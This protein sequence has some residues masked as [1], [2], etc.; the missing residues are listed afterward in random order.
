MIK[1]I[2]QNN[3][4]HMKKI[5]FILLLSFIVCLPV[6]ATDYGDVSN[7]QTGDITSK[8]VTIDN[9]LTVSSPQ[10]LIGN[11]IAAV[12]GLVG[13]VSL[14]MFIVGGLTWMTAAGS[15]DKIKK[16]KNIIT[17]ATIG[18]VVIFSSYAIVKL[19]FTDILGA[20]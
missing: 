14:L 8:P 5:I 2:Y 10:A 13:S 17:W 19:L 20:K 12:L 3:N 4:N 6:F 7:Q 9:P 16:G 15:E 18:L 11:I 1:L